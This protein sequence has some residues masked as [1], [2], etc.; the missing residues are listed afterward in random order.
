MR[1]TQ[2]RIVKLFEIVKNSRI[3]P[4]HVEK[5][6]ASL[7]KLLGD[8]EKNSGQRVE[9]SFFNVNQTVERIINDLRIAG[10]NVKAEDMADEFDYFVKDFRTIADL[11]NREPDEQNLERLV[12]AL[13]K[14]QEQ[15]KSFFKRNRLR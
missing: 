4:I 2:E 13:E 8:L 10:N 5:V 3:V 15:L 14:L 7:Q 1:S 9:D 12:S 11:S 6:F